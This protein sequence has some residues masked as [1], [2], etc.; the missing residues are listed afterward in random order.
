MHMPTERR[1]GIAVLLTIGLFALLVSG[2]IGITP[3]L[4]DGRLPMLMEGK[5]TLFRKVLMRPRAIVS[6]QPGSVGEKPTVP[7]SVMFVYGETSKDGKT[8]LE[9]GSD[10]AGTVLGW[11][12]QSDTAAWR[13]TMTLA[14]TNPAGRQTTLLFRDRGSL[15]T[16]LGADDLLVK[17]ETF[18][19][20]I[21][22][23][24]LPSDGPVI[25]VEPDT[26]IDIKKQFYLLPI[27]DAEEVYLDSGFPMTLLHVTSVSDHS[28]AGSEQEN[29]QDP[30]PPEDLRAAVTFVIDATNSM[31]P[32][33]DQVRTSVRALYDQMEKA[34]I[35]DKISFGLVAYRDNLEAA[36]GLGYTSKV[37]ADP[38]KIKTSEEFLN[39]V[40]E[41]S[42][43]QASSRGFDEDAYAGINDALSAI[44]WDGFGARFIILVTDAGAR[45]GADPLSKTGM[46]SDQMRQFARSKDVYLYVM[47]LKTPAGAG[48]H[49]SAEAQ[50]RALSRYGADTN[51]NLYYPVIAGKVKNFADAIERVGTSI[52]GNIEEI[53]S[54][55]A[56]Q[57]ERIKKSRE[58][59]DGAKTEQERADAKLE[60]DTALVGLAIKL[61]YLGSKQGEQAPDVF[62]AWLAD[63]SFRDPDLPVVEVR[64]LLTKNQLSDLQQT[65]T[66]IIDASEAGQIAPDH[67][68]ESI[69]AAAAAMGRNGDKI[70]KAEKLADTGLVGEYLEGLPYRSTVMN[71][72]QDIWAS[73]GVGQQQQFI[74]TLRSKARLYGRY[75]DDTNNWVLLN[76]DAPAGDAVYPIPLDSLP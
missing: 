57:L 39:Q 56:V 47:H 60:Y 62:D 21:R 30:K 20:Q 59:L 11:V 19:E 48:D 27:L 34:G 51:S 29:A 8:W 54:D 33:I 74:D 50:Y 26:Y 6:V 5:K 76:P 55:R 31:G 58:A 52:I 42:P 41:L 7:F 36:P 67:F 40:A 72:S 18:R 16:L 22:R 17:A 49:Q 71:V 24:R 2:Q 43:A 38:S 1:R 10:S 15:E 14:F 69:K 63:R 61:R 25:S 45:E 13:Q 44:N 12:P 73:W 75:H 46:S 4:A 3:A 23:G 9:I 37:Y 65:L 28:E 66:R 68:F 32:Y 64:V 35:S 53:D 70:T